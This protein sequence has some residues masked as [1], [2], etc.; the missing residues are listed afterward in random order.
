MKISAEQRR[1]LD[2]AIE[3]LFAKCR[4]IRKHRNESR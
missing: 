4:E 2:M 3:R 1:K